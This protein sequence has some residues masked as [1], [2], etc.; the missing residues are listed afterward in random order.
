MDN[1]FQAMQVVLSVAPVPGIAAAAIA[2][3]EVHLSRDVS[4]RESLS[5]I[6]PLPSDLQTRQ[7]YR[8]TGV[9]CR[10]MRRSGGQL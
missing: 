5:L 2:I 1:L 8:T 7:S 6:E 4:Q 3:Q 10:W 9:S